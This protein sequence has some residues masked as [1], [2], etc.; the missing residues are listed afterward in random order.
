MQRTLEPDV[1][2]F[3]GDIGAEGEFAAAGKPVNGGSIGEVPNGTRVQEWGPVPGATATYPAASS[4]PTS[5][6]TTSTTTTSSSA[7]APAYPA[8]TAPPT[9]YSAPAPAPPTTTATRTQ[10]PSKETLEFE[11][12]RLG[13]LLLQALLKLDAV[14]FEGGWEEARRERKEAVRVVQRLLDRLDGGWRERKGFVV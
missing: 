8:P 3:L 2:R 6:S 1:E 12:T 11:H 14:S 7:T 13:E 10:P 4:Y 5:T 9:Q